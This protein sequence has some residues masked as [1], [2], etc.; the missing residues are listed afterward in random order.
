MADAKPQA[1][2][3]KRDWDAEEAQ[4]PSP[5][6]K[7]GGVGNGTSAPA[8]LPFSGFRVQKVLRESARDKIIV[9][10]GKVPLG[11]LWVGRGLEGANRR[12]ARR[13]LFVY[14]FI[15][16]DLGG[17]TPISAPGGGGVRR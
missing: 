16:V 11:R 6:Q 12:F 15:F 13:I 10:H 3:R 9:L 5:E 2:K 4:A 17:T 14:L 8:S 7:E 1:I